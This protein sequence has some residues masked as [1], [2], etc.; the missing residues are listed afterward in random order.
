MNSRTNRRIGWCFSI[1]LLTS[2]ATEARALRVALEP[3]DQGTSQDSKQEDFFNEQLKAGAALFKV[4]KYDEALTKYQDL[5][6]QYPK[7]SAVYFNIGATYQAKKDL[8]SAISAYQR[9]VDLTPDND[10]YRKVILAAREIKAGPLIEKAKQKYGEKDYAAAI[11]LYQQAFVILPKNS[12]L[13]HN[14]AT[15]LY[16]RQQYDRAQELFKTSV[17]LDPKEQADDLFTIAAIDEHFG[18]GKDALDCYR[19]YLSSSPNGTHSARAKERIEALTVNMKNVIKLKPASEI[20]Q[21][22]EATDLFNQALELHSAKKFD[23]AL[24]LYRKAVDLQPKNANFLYGL[25]TLYSYK[26]EYDEAIQ[27]FEKA[28]GLAPK[29][30]DYPYAIGTA[31]QAKE[32]FDKAI[33]W[34][35]KAVA[36][37]PDNKDFQKVL[38]QCQDI[39]SAP[40]MDSAYKMHTSGKIVEA[41]KLYQ[42]GLAIS[43]S[44]APGWTNLATAYQDNEDFAKARETFKKALD[45]DPKSQAENWFYIALLDDHLGQ[46][47]KALESYQKYIS[48]ASTPARIAYAKDR[49][50]DL[51]KDL[52]A[53][54]KLPKSATDKDTQKKE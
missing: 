51:A 16:V 4:G 54:K 28:A 19:D 35:Q 9:A 46:G 17:A 23:E 12:A 44:N 48:S 53:T 27:L 25:G 18:R 22:S 21:I 39:K 50:T 30:A 52:K 15:A 34:Y 40:L 6:K 20:V 13:A 1:I 24:L 36:L 26:K 47:A 14:L 32:N 11:D 49:V 42:Q 7:E 2:Q 33:S 45:L 10:D 31:F 8:D 41:V 29:E 37:A 3:P 38:V 5:L 43:P